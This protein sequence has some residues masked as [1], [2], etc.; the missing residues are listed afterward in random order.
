VARQRGALAAAL[1]DELCEP[2]T[3]TVRRR[4]AARGLVRLGEGGRAYDLLLRHHSAALAVG[5]RWLRP[6]RR[7]DTQGMGVYIAEV[8]HAVC[9]ALANAA[10]DAGAAFAAEPARA[11]SLLAWAKQGVAR[12]AELL[13][14]DE[15][16]CGAGASLHELAI[17]ARIA[18]AHA[19]LL[20]PYGL[21]VGPLLASLLVRASCARLLMHASHGLTHARCAAARARVGGAGGGAVVRRAR[22]GADHRGGGVPAR[23][24]VPPAA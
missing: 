6:P 4:A 3:P 19:A 13:L 1:A 15:S 21:C 9:D 17:G 8:S 2:S 12:W 18:L 14:A 16:S 5:L 24:H 23:R 20:E 11:S 7:D 22:T 10:L